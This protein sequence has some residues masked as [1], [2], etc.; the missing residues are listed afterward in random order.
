MQGRNASNIIS[1]DLYTN[2]LSSGDLYEGYVEN[3][4]YA[5]YENIPVST[6]IN[7]TTL[8]YDSYNVCKLDISPKAYRASS[9][10]CNTHLEQYD[11]S[12]FTPENV[13]KA[14]SALSLSIMVDDVTGIGVADDILLPFVWAGGCLCYIAAVIYYK[15][16]GNGNSHYPGPWS[17][18]QIPKTHYTMRE[19]IAMPNPD[20]F[21]NGGGNYFLPGLA[22]AIQD[23]YQV[24]SVDTVK[25]TFIEHSVEHN[26]RYNEQQKFKSEYFYFN[27]KPQKVVKPSI[28]N[29]FK[30]ARIIEQLYSKTLVL[31]K[32]NT[33]VVRKEHVEPIFQK[34]KSE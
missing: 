4:G 34:K 11:D 10:I 28:I 26:Y 2:L 5:F 6:S 20:N 12:W 19:P 32:D 18:T 3:C 22:Y 17:E 14:T 8:I 1:L 27:P 21:S 16:V 30:I 9:K 24:T 23:Y 7:K 29:K 25:N 13:L 15:N 33:N 31:P